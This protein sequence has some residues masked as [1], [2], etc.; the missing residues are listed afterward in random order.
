MSP[1]ATTPE[2][3]RV[4]AQ[5]RHE[6]TD[7]IGRALVAHTVLPRAEDVA[8]LTARLRGYVARLV[9]VV[10]DGISG[11]DPGTA[12]WDQGTSALAEARRV[13]DAGPGT[14]L[15]SAVDHMQD[16]GRACHRLRC[17]LPVKT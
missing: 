9:P 4:T 7:V 12:E 15:R 17:H 3:G 6:L 14:G 16:L 5:M 1:G 2:T 10:E 13:L 8:D 11:L